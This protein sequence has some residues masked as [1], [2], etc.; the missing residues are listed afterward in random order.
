[1]EIGREEEARRHVAEAIKKNP[2]A[3]LQQVRFSEPYQD[4]EYLDGYL[5][6][7]RRAGMPE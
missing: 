1:M 7:L 3:S 4:E 2:H 6:L 5:D